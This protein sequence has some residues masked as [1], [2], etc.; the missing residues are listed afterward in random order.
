[1]KGSEGSEE[2]KS[3]DDQKRKHVVCISHHTVDIK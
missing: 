1:M 3:M 2:I